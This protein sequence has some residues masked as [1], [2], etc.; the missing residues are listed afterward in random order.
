M[1]L[2]A[3]HQ[4][5]QAF[6]GLQLI[7]WLAIGLGVGAL[8]LSWGR[9]VAWI[10]APEQRPP[11]LKRWGEDELGW[12]FE[13]ER[14]TEQ[15]WQ[16]ESKSGARVALVPVPGEGHLLRPDGELDGRPVTLVSASGLRLSL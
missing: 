7:S 5:R 11:A 1:F 14:G 10:R 12:Y 2:H 8:V 13:I 9:L 6:D 16:A 4:V 3:A 15:T